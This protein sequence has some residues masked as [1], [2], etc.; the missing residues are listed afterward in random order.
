MSSLRKYLEQYVEAYETGRGKTRYK[1]C[2]PN[3]A[4][5]PFRKQGFHDRQ[6]ALKWAELKHKQMLSGKGLGGLVPSTLSFEEYARQRL[7]KW[8]SSGKRA[9]T[10]QR[11]ES[12]LR[13]RL[14]PYFGAV[15]LRELSKGHLLAYMD[16]LQREGEISGTSLYFSV[17]LFK[18]IIREAERN[19][20]IPMTGIGDVEMP[21]KDNS[22]PFFWSP[23]EIEQFLNATKDHPKHGEWRLA[24]CTGMR[25][26]EV[27]ALR[28]ECVHLDEMIG[29]H[30]GFIH[31]K[32]SF[33][34]KTKR[35]VETTK[36]GESRLIPIMPELKEWLEAN[37][38]LSGY[39]LG[40]GE[41]PLENTHFARDV[42][43]MA[44][45]LG[46][47]PITFHQLRHSA[48]SWLD[49]LGLERRIVQK[50]MGHKHMRTTER[51]SHVEESTLG[52]VFADWVGRGQQRSSNLRVVI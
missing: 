10:I 23:K 24:L 41:S 15:R 1:V 32:R 19:D 38:R 35:V 20:E 30:R 46:M 51:Y 3:G 4:G 11:Y 34:Q 6:M 37:R 8:I 25:A 17:S 2:L 26:G 52:D 36:N 29:A 28:W 14:I 43:A 27:I 44:I 31:V 48:C 7:E 18:K 47:R 21:E 33:E 42:R 40:G 50:I 13:I 5:N 45:K 16:E 49:G 9:Q 39:V 22:E 12:E